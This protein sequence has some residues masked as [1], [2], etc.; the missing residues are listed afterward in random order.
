MHSQ[1]KNH[2]LDAFGRPVFFYVT[3]PPMHESGTNPKNKLLVIVGPTASGK[4][5]LA[6]ELAK[7]FNGEVISAD[8][9]QVYR[10]MDIGTAKVTKEEMDSVPHHL[11]DIT[12]PKDIYTAADFKKD[13][14]VAIEDIRARDKLAIIC[15]GT[16]FYID[17]L[18]G[19]TSLPEVEINKKLR[20]ELA[21]K[22]A[23]ELFSILQNLD[24]K[25]ASDID[26]DNKRRLIRAI[27]IAEAVGKVP[28][29]DTA[30]KTDYDVLTIGLEVNMKVHGEKLRQRILDRLE[31]GM[32]AEVENLLTKGLTHERL[33]SFGLEY[34]YISRYLQGF[35][36][37]EEMVNELTNKSR[38]FA[39]RQMT[40]L[41]RDKS[42]KW[43]SYEDSRIVKVVKEFLDKN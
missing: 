24:T 13:A 34:R 33:E 35:L 42:I 22:S 12:D 37:K 26:K 10:G 43:F 23:A 3:L 16:F 20:S 4:T 14:I 8:S 5:A 30:N 19:K 15:G 29:I 17:A 7:Q 36:T 25:R 2:E 41:K 27:E 38:Q 32:V 18:L 6:V 9:R 11:L 1:V 40:W 21:E 39:K 31:I 28:P